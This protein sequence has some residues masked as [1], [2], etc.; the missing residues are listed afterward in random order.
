MTTTSSPRNW[1]AVYTAPKAEKKVSERFSALEIEHY[2]PLK[3]VKHQW[4]DR[5]KELTVPVIHGYIFV[6]IA[7]GEVL[8]VRSVYGAMSFIHKGGIPI[9][10]PAVQIE[11]MRTMVEQSAASVEFTTTVFEPGEMIRVNS[12][13]LEGLVGELVETNGKHRVM[14]RLEGFGA[15]LT[16]IP[17]SFISKF[18]DSGMK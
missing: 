7:L 10:I 18:S 4:S 1:Y 12:G 6:N 8:K 17:L 13:A 3:R 16:T 11:R 15:A 2:L 14:I 9:A 5:V